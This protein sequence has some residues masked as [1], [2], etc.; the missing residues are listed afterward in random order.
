M[1]G[2]CDECHQQGEVV[3]VIYANTGRLAIRCMEHVNVQEDFK[4]TKD[5]GEQTE[6]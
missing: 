4:G 6:Q 3:Q 2:Y 1:I 5:G